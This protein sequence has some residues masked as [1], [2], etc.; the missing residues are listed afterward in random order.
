MQ[1]NNKILVD[2]TKKKNLKIERKKKTNSGELRKPG[3]VSQTHNSL[4]YRLGLN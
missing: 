3:L 1:K 4:N 2:E